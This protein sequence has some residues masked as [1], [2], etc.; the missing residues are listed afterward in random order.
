MDLAAIYNRSSG[1]LTH[2][3]RDYYLAFCS[4]ADETGYC[5]PRLKTVATRAG[6]YQGNGSRFFLKLVKL[7]FMERSKEGFH[8]ILGFEKS[9]SDNNKSSSSNKKS[10]SHNNFSSEPEIVSQLSSSSDS[11]KSCCDSNSELAHIRNRTIK[12]EKKK[13]ESDPPELKTFRSSLVA[14]QKEFAEPTTQGKVIANMK[15]IRSLFDLSS[16]SVDDCIATHKAVQKDK[17]RTGRVDWTHVVQDWN[18]RK[19]AR[20]EPKQ[21]GCE[22]CLNHPNRNVLTVKS[23]GYIFDSETE[24][25]RLCVCKQ[26]NGT[27]QGQR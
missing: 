24:Q 16:G 15:A 18:F 9:S 11:N 3:E 5:Y 27:A 8:C 12:K 21:G 10:S 17:W 4:F 1:V 13:K 26:T 7:G 19:D 22:I 25:V 23:G 20:S 14:F 2:A 6:T